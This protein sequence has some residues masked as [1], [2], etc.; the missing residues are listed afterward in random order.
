MQALTPEAVESLFNSHRTVN[1]FEEREVAQETLDAIYNLTKMGPTAFNSQPLRITWVRSEEARKR[2]VPLMMP[3]NQDKT[4]AAPVTA[5]LSWD[6]NWVARFPDFCPPAAD[7]MMP[8]YQA[9]E[10]LAES[11]GNNNAHLQAGYFITAIR[12]LGLAAGPMTGA[13]FAQIDANFFPDQDRASFLVVNLGYGI[14]PEYG[15]HPRFEA[16]DVTETI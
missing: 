13:D 15:R 6:K 1:H 9:N 7:T 10:A 16:A 8:F 12:A 2:L 5:I 14:A 4:A 11:T 3:G